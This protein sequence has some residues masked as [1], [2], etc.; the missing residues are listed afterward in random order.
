MN[1]PQSL[2]GWLDHISAQHSATIALGL[3]RVS[4]IAGRMAIRRAPVVITVGGT[5]GKGSTCAFLERILVEAGYR[6]G[7]YTSPHL[8]RYGER[9]RVNGEEANDEALCGAFAAVEAARAGTPLT[10]FEFG[11]LAALDLFGRAS[12][13]ALVLEVG[14]GGRLDAVNIVDADCAIVSSVDLDHQAFLGDT[15]EKIGFEK[16]GIFRAGRPAFFGDADPPQS[17][18]AYARA[19]GA[20]LQVLGRD[21]GFK[22]EADQWQFHGREGKHRA[23][24]IPALRGAWQL[25][26]ASTA[27][28][29]LAALREKLPVSLAEI[30]QGLTRVQLQGRLQVLPGRP[31]TVLDVAHNPHAARALADG[32]L[33]MGFFESTTAVFAMLND[34]DIGGVI[35]ALAER[36]DRWLVAPLP[37]PRGATAGQLAGALAARGLG[38]RTRRFTTVAAALDSARREAGP[39]DRIVA[40]GSFLTVAEALQAPN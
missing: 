40:F 12:L 18:L 20:D 27:L 24:P 17:L 29:A 35:D 39:N 31:T 14:M 13:D 6:A 9:V 16:A 34:K 30:K 2:A 21:F 7:L 11:T 36:I 3:E 10:Y 25:K 32:L 4:E 33:D 19:I 38:E 37:G 8:L 26:N 15:R 22:R 23:L 28:A 5:N 1:A